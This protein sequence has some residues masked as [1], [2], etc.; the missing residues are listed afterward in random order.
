MDVFRELFEASDANGD[1]V[2]SLKEFNTWVQLAI[3]MFSFF[4]RFQSLA[5]GFMEISDSNEIQSI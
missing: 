5:T 2:I 4:F 1:N 3:Y